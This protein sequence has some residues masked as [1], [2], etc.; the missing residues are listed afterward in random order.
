MG[1]TLNRDLIRSAGLLFA[2]AVAWN[3]VGLLVLAHF[4]KARA[5]VELQHLLFEQ[6]SAFGTV[7]L[8]TGTTTA[9][10]HV[11]SKLWIIATMYVGRLG[12]LTLVSLAVY[13]RSSRVTFPEGKVMVG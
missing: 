1:R 5:G 3:L 11:V 12:P 13:R 9:G 8:S 4:E 10:L 6:I 7:G 2:L